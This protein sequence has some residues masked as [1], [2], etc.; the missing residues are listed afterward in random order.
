MAYP[1]DGGVILYMGSTI[2]AMAPLSY[3]MIGKTPDGAV[4]GS[5]IIETTSANSFVSVNAAAGNTAAIGIPP[6]S[7]TTN[8]NATTV[9]FKQL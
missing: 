8:T 3:S 1:T 7:S 6:N 2:D 9:S 5:V 4:F